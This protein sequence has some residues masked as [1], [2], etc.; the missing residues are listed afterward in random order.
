MAVA[1]VVRTWNAD[2]GWGVL[3]SAETPGGCWAHFSRAAVSGYAAF[4]ARQDVWLEW[5]SP[6]QDGYPFR[7]VRFWPI[8]AEPV[9]RATDESGGAYHSTLSITFD[10]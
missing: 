4:A 6:G 5:E 3:D 10:P 9:D 7:A 1:A 2:E 8:D